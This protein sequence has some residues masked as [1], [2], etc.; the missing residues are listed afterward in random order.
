MTIPLIA[1]T[2]SGA[3]DDVGRSVKEAFFMLWETIW[4]LV[5]GL[6]LSGA[7][8]AFASRGQIEK[9]LGDHRVG[10]VLR[11]SGLG[12]VSSSCSY[13]ASAL[14]R[15]LFA[16]GADFTSAMVFMFASTNLVFEIGIVLVVLIGWQFA[17]AEFVGGAIM[18]ALLVVAGGTV[19]RGR[20]V[21]RALGH[22]ERSELQRG[23]GGGGLNG[24]SANPATIRTVRGWADAAGFTISDLKM[25]RRELVF[26]YLVA[27]G[28][29]T[30]VPATAWNDLFL[31]NHGEWTTLE[32]AVV[33]PLVAVISCVCSIG[34]VPLAAA[35]WKGGISF[36]GVVSF[37]FAD[38]IALPLLL[39]YR[40]FYGTRVALALLGVFWLV[41]SGAGLATGEIFGAA[42]L[43]PRT[44]PISIAPE[45]IGWNA[46]TALNI[47]LGCALSAM[48]WLHRNRGRSGV[49]NRFAID[50]VC[51]MQVEIDRAPASSE[52]RGVR[53]YFCSDRCRD[54]Y[55]ARTPGSVVSSAS[56]E[57]EVG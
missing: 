5:L 4:A 3:L 30:V 26:G 22:V 16:K 44:R 11:A 20:F 51:G 47:A 24:G 31:R 45:H 12:M 37:I 19:F 52:L 33:G 36:G 55:L 28:L 6:G 18:I 42:G 40:N 34:N 54:R 57:A 50:P 1:L 9:R 32:N 39:V 10:S 48:F 46:T 14:A 15:S 7:V 13:A 38:L 8:Q 27:G 17:A 53:S 29:A 23:L 35:L 49:G 21:Q 25:L 2:A 43:V 41:M 56:V